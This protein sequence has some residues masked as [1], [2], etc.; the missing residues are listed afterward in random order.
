MIATLKELLPAIETWPDEDQQA[1]V[2]AARDIAAERSGLYR[3]TP[4]EL[5]GVDR[6]LADAR[7]G[8]FA[9]AEEIAAI[10]ARYLI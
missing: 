4:A 5:A 1:L 8:R 7:A 9:S 6:G 3:A 2:N 10:R